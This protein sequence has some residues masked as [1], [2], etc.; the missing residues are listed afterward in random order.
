[1]LSKNTVQRDCLRAI[2]SE[3][4]NQ[5]VNAGKEITEDICMSVIK[6]SVKQHNDSIQ[7]FTEGNRSD[8][9]EKEKEELKY[10]EI[11]LPSM[12]DETKTREV[13]DI[14]ISEN[15]IDLIKKN[16]GVIMKMINSREDKSMIDRKIVSQYLNTILK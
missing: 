5:T 9:A 10:I 4:K 7:N 15:K 16:M 2:M 6:K 13:I 1:M 8:L 12:Y 14:M 11:Y 3:I